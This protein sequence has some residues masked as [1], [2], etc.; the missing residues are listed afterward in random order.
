MKSISE[1]RQAKFGLIP[2]KDDVTLWTRFLFPT[3]DKEVSKALGKKV[4]EI[5]GLRQRYVIS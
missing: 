5:K 2:T 1:A 4:D 3:P